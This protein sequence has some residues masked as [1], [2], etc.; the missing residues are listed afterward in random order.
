[1]RHR[2]RITAP[3]LALLLALAAAGAEASPGPAELCRRAGEAAALRHGVPP[4]LMQA[5]ALVETGR[6]RGGVRAP[7]PWTLNIAGKGHWLDSRAAARARAEAALAA[8]ERSV[9][10]GC[11]QIN[12]R[13]HGMAFASLDAM[14]DPA[15]SADYAARFLAG[16]AAET[17][18]WTVAAGRYHSRTPVHYRR[19]GALIEAALADLGAAPPSAAPA[20]DTAPAPR[21]AAAS[22]PRAGPAPG[23]IGL[24][25]LTPGRAA[26]PSGT[27]ALLRAARG[28]FLAGLR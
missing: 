21:L 28:P 8:G 24:E 18:D 14:L 3:A 26:L 27:R 1:M 15:R 9:D 23:A 17:G 4:A 11:F 10:L 13:W 20:P 6:T 12:Y 25:T 19:Y 5:I 22:R 2:H 16:L 7:W